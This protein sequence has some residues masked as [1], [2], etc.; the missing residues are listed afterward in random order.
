MFRRAANF[1]ARV[2]DALMF[3]GQVGANVRPFLAPGTL[4][5]PVVQVTGGAQQPGLLGTAANQL[6]GS[7]GVGPGANPLQGATVWGRAFGVTRG[8]V[9]PPGGAGPT[10]IALVGDIV[11][12]T[13]VLEAGG[14]GP[15]YA[16]VLSSTLYQA[17][18]TPTPS[19]VLPRD[20]I[21]PLLGDGPL[22][23]SSLLRPG[24]GL[25]VPCESGQIEQVLATDIC[26]KLL[27]VSE[28]PRF[29]FRIS[30][31]VALRVKDWSAVVNIHP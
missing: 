8:P 27:Q 21:M 15:P 28:E 20:T 2:E 29:V 5:P 4:V 7:P 14:Y 24:W 13:N 10:G 3:Y 22:L 17:V 6:P 31:R 11:A 1:I 9:N 19:L 12:A 26:V 30:E 16:C 25:V 18:H 23:R